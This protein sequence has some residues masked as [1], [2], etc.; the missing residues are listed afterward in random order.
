MEERR[1]EPRTKINK[2]NSFRF[3]LRLCSSCF[4]SGS[5][6]VIL[7]FDD[8]EKHSILQNFVYS[9][10]EPRDKKKIMEQ[11][12]LVEAFEKNKLSLKKTAQGLKISEDELY[13][14][15]LSI[16]VAKIEKLARID[17]EEKE[18][19]EPNTKAIPNGNHT[20]QK[21]AN[22]EIQQHKNTC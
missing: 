6:P 19:E 7:C 9:Y 1:D 15:L 12:K 10:E 17:Q 21:V 8:F 3:V 16:P 20:H 11:N 4:T 5:I 18:E 14:T 13:D 22:Q 2:Q